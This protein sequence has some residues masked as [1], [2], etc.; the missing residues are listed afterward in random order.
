MIK[1]LYRF[2]RLRKLRELREE[3]QFVR[4]A[5]QRRENL[6]K[7]A[8]ELATREKGRNIVTGPVSE[9]LESGYPVYESE[10]PKDSEP[11]LSIDFS[12]KVGHESGTL[13]VITY[14]GKIVYKRVNNRLEV[15]SRDKKE[16][17]VALEEEYKRIFKK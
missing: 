8:V 3:K 15:Y 17:Q 5:V 14:E 1:Q 9:S 16:W 11:P 6:E 2:Y 4:E 12:D 13:L 7:I 10:H